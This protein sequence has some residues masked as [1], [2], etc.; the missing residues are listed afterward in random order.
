[1]ISIFNKFHI[2]NIKTR[3]EEIMLNIIIAQIIVVLI[4][5]YIANT[6]N[7]FRLYFVTFLFNLSNL[8]SKRFQLG[9]F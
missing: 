9:T 5:V 2:D 6:E 4:N 7:K 1:M 3:K 8:K